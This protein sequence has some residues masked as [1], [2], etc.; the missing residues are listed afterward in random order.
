MKTATVTIRGMHCDGCAETVKA[1]L[2]GEPGV[3]ASTVSFREGKA[4]V[5]YDP[6]ATST[7][8]LIA[9]IERAGYRAAQSA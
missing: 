7:D 6:S 4:R 2:A 3:K 9:V 1:L 8:R 5:L